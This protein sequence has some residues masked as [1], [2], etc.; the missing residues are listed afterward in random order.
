[1]FGEEEIQER[2]GEAA[3]GQTRMQGG[4]KNGIRDNLRH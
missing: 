2:N 1:M 3:Q 4:M